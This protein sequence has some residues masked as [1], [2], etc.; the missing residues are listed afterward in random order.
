MANLIIT[1]ERPLCKQ[2]MDSGTATPS[3]YTG[4]MAKFRLAP[5]GTVF[6]ALKA[7]LDDFSGSNVDAVAELLDTAGRFLYRL[8]ETHV[9]MANMADVRSAA[10]L[11]RRQLHIMWETY[12]I[13]ASIMRTGVAH[14]PSIS[15]PQV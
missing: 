5:F 15:C 4:E 14:R 3:V 6:S 12:T 8:P 1:S 11:A 10:Q 13:A 7:M 2:F 9:R